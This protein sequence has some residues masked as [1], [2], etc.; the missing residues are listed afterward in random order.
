M[1]ATP[2]LDPVHS[3][4]RAVPALE[5]RGLTK[6]YGR[7][8]NAVTAV[9]NVS[10]TVS[11][12]QVFGLLGPNGAGKTTTIKM[13]TGLVTPTEG[14]ALVGGYD[15]GRQRGDAVRQIGA[16][17]EGSRNV[18]WSLTAWQN[19]HYFGRLKGLRAAQI[20]PRAEQLLRELGLWERRHQQVGV[21]SRGMQQKVAVAAALVTDPPIVLLDEP[22]IGLDV[23]AAR[24]VRRWIVRLARDE[25][26]TVVLT[27]HQLA[28][29]EEL[30][31]RVVVIR[32]GRVVADLPTRELLDRYVEDRYEVRAASPVG[33]LADVLPAGATLARAD[34]QARI[35]LPSADQRPLHALLATL[36]EREVPVLSVNRVQPGLE[37][38]FV[39]LVRGE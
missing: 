35:E 12:G 39:K 25:G 20:R 7:G 17:L 27:T 2:S 34:G 18:Y 21:F 22:T 24:T 33:E 31:D 1:Q 5:V 13:L 26:K 29:A 16:V 3:A 36:R 4:V 9:D 38:I 10:F 28:M 14:A 23:D 19:L 37:E 30:S 32:D 15:V 6:R 8:P 11:Y